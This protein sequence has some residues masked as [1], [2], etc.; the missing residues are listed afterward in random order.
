[1]SRPT[2]RASGRSSALGLHSNNNQK[3]Q[4]LGGL[5]EKQYKE[6]ESNISSARRPTSSSSSAA[7]VPS[8]QHTRRPSHSQGT[9]RSAESKASSRNS[10]DREELEE[11]SE[12]ETVSYSRQ[13]KAV[14]GGPGSSRPPI[15][16]AAAQPASYIASTAF[17][18]APLNSRVPPAS[19]RRDL[20]PRASTS[21]VSQEQQPFSQES[22]ELDGASAQIQEA[23]LVEDLLSVLMVRRFPTLCLCLP[24]LA[25][26]HSVFL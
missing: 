13:G 8:S 12:E 3:R 20:P 7:G 15:A 25:S 6:I 17:A 11:E 9:S 5:S 24:G 2:S 21:K 22:I 4:H 23:L 18:A 10:Y 14:F 26:T 1:M 16:P 19:P